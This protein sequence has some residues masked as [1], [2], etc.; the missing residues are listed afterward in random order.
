MRTSGAAFLEPIGP[1][2]IVRPQPE[3]GA[4]TVLAPLSFVMF[5]GRAT[6]ALGRH[7]ALLVAV[8]ERMQRRPRALAELL[9]LQR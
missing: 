7:P 3:G 8:A 5:D 2:C 4:W 1:G 6:A 9:G